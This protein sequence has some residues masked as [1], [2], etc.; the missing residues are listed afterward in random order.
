MHKKIILAKTKLILNNAEIPKIIK[1]S[2]KLVNKTARDNFIFLYLINTI[3]PTARITEIPA[4]KIVLM[5]CFPKEN[6]IGRQARILN[7]VYQ[8]YNTDE[9]SEK[10]MIKPSNLYM[11][12]GRG[13][14]ML[15]KCLKEQGNI[16]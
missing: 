6:D 12:L 15:R 14:K 3:N 4:I 10:L 8:G 7:L 9:I 16:R 5:N 2:D 13:R 1:T 11:I